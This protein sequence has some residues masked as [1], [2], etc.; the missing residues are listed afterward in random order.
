MTTG[1]LTGIG[2]NKRADGAAQ[3]V[4]QVWGPEFKS[5]WHKKER[6]YELEC[7]SSVNGR[8]VSMGK[9]NRK[10]KEKIWL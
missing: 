5:Q 1:V 2:E 6:K 4:E 10:G 3:V 7:S 9:G 8:K